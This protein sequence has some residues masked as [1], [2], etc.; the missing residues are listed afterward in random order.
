MVLALL[1]TCTV[2]PHLLFYC[3]AILSSR[4]VVVD[5]WKAA[6]Q[7]TNLPHLFKLPLFTSRLTEACSHTHDPEWPTSSKPWASMMF[8]SPAR[9]QHVA[10]NRLSAGPLL[11]V[12]LLLLLLMT[13]MMMMMLLL[14]HL[15]KMLRLPLPLHRLRDPGWLLLSLPLT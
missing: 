1:D 9:P 6:F 2:G 8:G 7:G 3:Y 14:R 5:V 12:A 15:L 13:T 10:C 4:P 11:E